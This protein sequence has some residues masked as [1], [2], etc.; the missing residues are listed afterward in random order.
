[1]RELPAGKISEAFL[2]FAQPLLDCAPKRITKEQIEKCMMFAFTVWNSVVYDSVN[3]NS[4]YVTKIRRLLAKDVQA[5][6]LLEGMIS[7]KKE[8]FGD[9]FRLIGEYKITKKFGGWNF[10]V[11]ARDPWNIKSGNEQEE[12]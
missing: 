4:K 1:R 10:R 3:G 6:L 5:A 7:R 8:L 11:E 12:Q 9:D 2:D